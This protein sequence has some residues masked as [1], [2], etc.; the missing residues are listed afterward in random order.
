MVAKSPVAFMSYSRFVDKHDNGRLTDFRE[1]LAGEVRVQTGEDF[2]IFQDRSDIGW[3]QAWEERIEKSLDDAAFLIPIITPGYFTSDMCR[4]E[5]DRFLRRESFL[6]RMDLLLPVYYVQSAPIEENIDAIARVISSRNYVDWRQLRFEPPTSQQIGRAF[7]S[8]AKHIVDA[9]TRSPESADFRAEVRNGV[10]RDEKSS[11][12]T[13]GIWNEAEIVT[14]RTV[15]IRP[16]VAVKEPTTLIVDALHRGNYPTISA[17]LAAA[18]PG[19]RI[20]VRPGLYKENIVFDKPVEIIGDG[21]PEDIVVEVLGEANVIRFTTTMGRVT[22]L[23]LRHLGGE[24]SGYCVDIAGGRLDLED[25]HITSRGLA[26]VV[27]HSGADPRLRR[28]RIHGGSQ[29]GVVVYGNGQGTLEDNDIFDN[30]LSGVEITHGGN[31]TLRRNRI[32]DGKQSGIYVHDNGQG[33]LEDNEIFRNRLAGVAIKRNGNPMLRRNRIHD[34][35]QAGVMVYENG[36]GTLEHNEIFGNTLPGVTIKKGGNP[37]FRH[38]HIHSGKA[39]GIF[40][41]DGGRGVIEDNDVVGNALAGVEV[42]Q[43]D[44]P[45]FRKNRIIEN[46]TFAICASGEGSGLFEDNDLSNNA[47]GAWDIAP[48]AEGGL[49]RKGNRES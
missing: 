12:P 37:I 2:H 24:S 27:I 47:K 28:N 34:G 48:E 29:G 1:R 39:G 14:L 38:N 16:P 33:T 30:A 49:V 15:N 20:L 43:A 22:N 18:T 13:G 32:H 17:A 11:R 42:K 23:T 44:N 35:S 40:V 36:Q 10:G 46:R 4:K 8:L 6:D 26:C 41:H 3:G 31:P 19:S 9:L 5:F 7:E 25:C 45:V 21:S